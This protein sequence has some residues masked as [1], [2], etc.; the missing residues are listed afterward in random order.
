MLIQRNGLVY[1]R[2]GVATKSFL[3][4][5]CGVKLQQVRVHRHTYENIV[6]D[7]STQLNVT[8]PTTISKEHA[9]E[10]NTITRA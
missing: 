4:E 1:L 7:R 10:Y 9:P 6:Q 5:S 2:P 3:V 8:L